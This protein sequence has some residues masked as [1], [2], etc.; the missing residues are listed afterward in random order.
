[1]KQ[2]KTPCGECPWRKAS[3]PGWLGADTPE[4]FAA[5]S[6]AEV[7]MPCHIHVDYD[8]DDWEEQ[9]DEA[10]QCAGRA[11]HF[12]NRCKLPHNPDVAALVKEVERSP[13]VFTHVHDFI[14]HHNS[15]KKRA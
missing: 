1:V 6:E 15:F 2:H 5:T 7:R 9:A 8:R 11:I 13:D 4:G 10:P 3:A 14:D 12:K